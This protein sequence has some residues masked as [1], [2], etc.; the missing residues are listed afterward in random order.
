[1]GE[2]EDSS[3]PVHTLPAAPAALGDETSKTGLRTTLAAWRGPAVALLSAP[4]AV[5]AASSVVPA[6]RA[7]A[8]VE[9][10]ETIDAEGASNAPAMP[11]TG[12]GTD[13]AE[14][15][16]GVLSSAM[17]TVLIVGAS[18]GSACWVDALTR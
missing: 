1:M 13:E 16:T 10:E 8:P 15:C 7:A 11:P 6:V 12:A 3:S 5:G 9:A 17:R 4:A 18:I 14:G 2:R